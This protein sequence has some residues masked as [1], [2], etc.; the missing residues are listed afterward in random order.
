MFW[1]T[2]QSPLAPVYNKVQEEIYKN[3]NLAFNGQTD[4]FFTGFDNYLSKCGQNTYTEYARL[5]YNKIGSFLKGEGYSE[6]KLETILDSLSSQYFVNFQA[7]D[8]LLFVGVD[9]ETETEKKWFPASLY[10]RSLEIL[11]YLE[12]NGQIANSLQ[13]TIEKLRSKI[14]T[15]IPKGLMPVVR[16]DPVSSDGG[17][18]IFEAKI[19]QRSLDAGA[20]RPIALVPVGA[21]YIFTNMIKV[22]GTKTPLHF[23]AASRIGVKAYNISTSPVFYGKVYSQSNFGNEE[24]FTNLSR[25][26]V[27]FDLTTIRFYAYNLE[28]SFHEYG[29]VN[30]RPEMLNVVRPLQI[31]DIDRSRHNINYPLLRAVYKEKVY[32]LTTEKAVDITF[33][34]VSTYANLDDFK[35]ALIMQGDKLSN[36]DLFVLMHQHPQVFG[37]LEEEVENHHSARLGV[38]EGMKR[39]ELPTSNTERKALVE[40]LL[41][42]GVVR[43]TAK[44]KTSNSILEVYATNNLHAL[45]QSLGDDY[46][47]KFETTRLRLYKAK[48]VLEQEELISRQD[49]EG[50]LVAYNIQDN[51]MEQMYEISLLPTMVT[52]HLVPY[53]ERAIDILFEKA[54][55]RNISKTNIL[56]RN[57]FATS[58]KDLY[59][60]VDASNLIAVEYKE[61]K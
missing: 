52:S 60:N 40:Q 12:A 1:V 7:L 48:E 56:Y 20:G 26:V 17:K 50:L 46:A 29:V 3:F 55:A 13:D 49:F 42:S 38:L 4:E 25:M 5:G 30:F 21:Y 22:L 6:G 35:D 28:A 51:I 37:N 41:L 18:P 27:G 45:V 34:D 43:I 61:Y 2:P 57:I 11:T 9:T 23:E 53:F 19:P 44:R 10:T 15:S 31:T 16:L 58:Q 54:Q 8:D 24:I 36:K 14:A 32:N 59:G 39:I 47:K 33:E